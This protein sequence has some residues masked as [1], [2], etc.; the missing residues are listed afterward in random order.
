MASLTLQLSQCTN[1]RK[2]IDVFR[3]FDYQIYDVLGGIPAPNGTYKRTQIS[4][5]IGADVAM[6]M[7]DPQIL[8]DYGAFA[9]VRP[10][11]TD[12]KHVLKP[13]KRDEKIWVVSSFYND[14]S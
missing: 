6:T 12:I 13:L 9:V 5:L 3:H 1:L 4:L 2:I 10:A 11:Q 14:V 7:S 8:G